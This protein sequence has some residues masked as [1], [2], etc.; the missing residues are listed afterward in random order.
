M[1]VRSGDTNTN[2]FRGSLAGTPCPAPLGET[3]VQ[4]GLLSQAQLANA[5]Q[6]QQ[7]GDGHRL[8]G[9]VLIDLGLVDQAAIAE[10]LADG[11]GVPFARQVS[12]IADPV[13]VE[14]L[15]CEFLRQHHVLPLFLVRG[16]LTVA[17]AEPSNLYLFE[18]IRRRTGHQVRVV[19]AAMDDID[20][21][22]EGYL[23]AANVF[24]IDEIY[25]D[26]R[27]TDFSLIEREV[28]ELT[29]LEEVA[30][31]GPVV[32][33]VNW[34]VYSAVQ[35][36][37]SDI[38]IEP[39]DRALRVRY[40]VDGRL[41]E[42]VRPPYQMSSAICSRVKIMADLDI[43][44]RRLP[45]DGDIHVLLEGRPV[46]LRVSTMP[47]RH[48]EKVVIRI[49]DSRNTVVS[50]ERLGMRS[51]MQEA[52]QSLLTSPNGI[53]LVTGPTGSGK[54]TTMYSA[55]ASIS[56]EELNIST[57]ED[58]I[59]A[60]LPG[61]NQFQARERTG[62]DFPV[63]LRSLLR[64]DPDVIMVGEIRDEETARIAAQAA[65]TG[66]L[67]LSTLH[68]NDACAAPVRLVNLGVEPF[69]VGAVLRGVLAQRLVRRVCPQCR[70]SVDVDPAIRDLVEK[71]VGDATDL[72][73]GAGCQR[74]RETGFSGRLGMFEL[75]V[76]GEGISD[77]L[78]SGD[79]HRRILEVALAEGFQTMRTDGLLKAAD[80]LTTVEEV[81]A[82][83]AA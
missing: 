47:G 20:S 17:A 25:E 29:D 77:A 81:I 57:I 54:S 43:A 67:V 50:P 33:L 6:A 40:R 7:E 69:L 23:P 31:H 83:A 49:I 4:K 34:L 61:V 27:E 2:D 73:R 28:A 58:P 53:V 55:L 1:N 24:V 22:I 18:D 65:M 39:G 32:K 44:E 37:A 64:Q 52:W 76:P 35:E 70:Q 15:P 16:V 3:L 75:L 78:V 5:L 60:V 56:N 8:L 30:G 63:A 74:C 71:T 79:S 45:Q 10:A 38:H 13:A 82:A 80:G 66:H 21:A 72:V 68:T 62:F 36:G 41:F 51:D 19:A 59:E 26:V 46:D 11:Y 14:L 9:E 12:R 42:K 48:G